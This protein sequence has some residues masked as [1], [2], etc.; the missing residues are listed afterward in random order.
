[1]RQASSDLL[2]L[3]AER[4]GRFSRTESVKKVIAGT[5]GMLTGLQI[6]EDLLKND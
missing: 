1:V 5:T 4:N 3:I 2:V 6:K